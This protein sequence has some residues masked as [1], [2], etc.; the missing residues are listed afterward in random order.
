MYVIV[1]A[2]ESHMYYLY[3]VYCM[4]FRS[5]CVVYTR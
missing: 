3:I 5:K 4:Y 1:C 2:E